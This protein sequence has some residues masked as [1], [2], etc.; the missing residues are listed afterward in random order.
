MHYRPVPTEPQH[1]EAPAIGLSAAIVPIEVD[2]GV[3]DPPS[4]PNLVGW[5]DRSAEPGALKGQSVITGHT[6]HTGGG[7]MDDVGLLERNDIVRVVTRNATVRY[8]VEGV[9]DLSKADVATYAQNLFGQD[10]G[11]GRLILIT[12]DDW[13]GSFYESNVIALAV[14]V[15]G[16]VDR[17]GDS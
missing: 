8:R 7:A 1:I 5:W 17:A 6:V 2:A 12:C 13:N 15:D 4:D 16:H 9:A 11:E 14:P 3:L 10:R